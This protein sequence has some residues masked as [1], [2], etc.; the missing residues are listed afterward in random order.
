MGRF[1]YL[2]RVTNP[3]FSAT[4]KPALTWYSD[5]KT[6]QFSTI[7]SIFCKNEAF[8]NSDFVDFAVGSDELVVG[9]RGFLTHVPGIG[10]VT[11]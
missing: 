9:L 8:F 10:M 4:N 1:A 7:S 5:T 11:Y 6:P 3:H 2:S